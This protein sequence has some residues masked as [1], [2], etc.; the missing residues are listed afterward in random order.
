MRLI[1]VLLMALTGLA[2]C[3]GE[4]IVAT[5]AQVARYD[6]PGT[7]PPTVKLITV[8]RESTGS[9]GHSALVINAP[10]QRVVFDPAGTFESEVTPE[11]NDVHFGITP[12]MER[13]YVDYHV[14]PAW[15]ADIQTIEVSAAVAEQLLRDVKAYGAVSKAYCARSVSSILGGTPGFQDIEETW[16]P[17]KL[18]NQFGDRRGVTTRRVHD[19]DPDYT[20]FIIPLD[21]R[22]GKPIT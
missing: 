5:N 6:T 9:G 7:P 16:S 10:S 22:T 1:A 11:Q 17:I 12:N 14:R 8:V 21:P 18:S 20:G 2:G 15:Y 3:G 4:V 19:G 13:A